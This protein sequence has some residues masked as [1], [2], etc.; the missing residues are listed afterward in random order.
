[1]EVAKDPRSKLSYYRFFPIAFSLLRRPGK[2]WFLPLQAGFI[3][4]MKSSYN[5][6]T[7]GLQGAEQKR[8]TLTRLDGA[9]YNEDLFRKRYS[10]LFKKKI[11]TRRTSII[12]KDT[13]TKMTVIRHSGTRQKVNH[14]GQLSNMHHQ[15]SWSERKP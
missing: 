5:L 1:M 11:C 2:T 14:I 9:R 12:P 6:K 3:F 4:C 13:L 15:S 7:D 8:L 10:Y